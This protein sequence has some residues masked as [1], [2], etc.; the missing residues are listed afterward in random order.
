VKIEAVLTTTMDMFTEF[1]AELLEL[2]ICS[3]MLADELTGELSIR[4]AR[5]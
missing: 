1:I 5:D 2:N 3:I 4:S